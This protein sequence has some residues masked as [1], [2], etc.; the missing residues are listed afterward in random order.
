MKKYFGTDGIRGI[1]NKTLTPEFAFNLGRILGHVL[2]KSDEEKVNVLIGRDTRISGELLEY[3][4]I[5]GLLSIGANVMRLGVVSTPA[6]AYLTK[7]LTSHAGIRS[8][9]RR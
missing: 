2:K 6:V 1:A 9:E 8:E 4:L 5:S 7:S 3:S